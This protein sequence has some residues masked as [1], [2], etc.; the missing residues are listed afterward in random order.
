MH[1]VQ[2]FK[3]FSHQAS[4]IC[5]ICPLLLLKWWEI[6]LV[7]ELFFLPNLR[8]RDVNREI[9]AYLSVRIGNMQR[10]GDE[11]HFLIRALSQATLTLKLR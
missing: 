10:A 7:N 9:C 2:P 1:Y 8:V 5:L 4:F 3:C 6:Y 11:I